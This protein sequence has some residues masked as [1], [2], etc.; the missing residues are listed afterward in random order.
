MRAAFGRVADAD[1]DQVAC[2]IG[3]GAAMQGAAVV[4]PQQGIV[5]QLLAEARRVLLDHLVQQRQ[6]GAQRRR[7]QIRPRGQSLGSV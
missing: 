6:R 7:V 4:G 2:R 1:A 5:R 3:S